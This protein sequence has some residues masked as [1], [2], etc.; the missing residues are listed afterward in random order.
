[1]NSE[2]AIEAAQS[3]AARALI[4]WSQAELAKASGVAASLID[5]FESGES[6]ALP[7]QAIRKIQAALEKAGVTFVPKNGG[8]VG[9]RLSKGAEAQYLGWNDLTAANDE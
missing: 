7:A 9:V 2:P 1:M 4:G 6:G 3:R 8:G 5:R